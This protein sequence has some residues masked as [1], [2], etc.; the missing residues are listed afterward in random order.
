MQKKKKKK[1]KNIMA[2]RNPYALFCVFAKP[3]IP[4]AKSIKI[5]S[6]LLVCC[7]L[8]IHA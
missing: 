6:F 4:K 5:A 8:C 1:K 2:T 3:T 7:F